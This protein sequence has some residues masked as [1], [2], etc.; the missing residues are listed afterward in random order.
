[1]HLR[2]RWLTDDVDA[3]GT[4]PPIT[5]G[6]ERPIRSLVAGASAEFSMLIHGGAGDRPTLK[7]QW[8]D[9]EEKAFESVQTLVL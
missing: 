2:L 3:D 7:L 6:L 1:M 9:D 4:E 5:H 8:E